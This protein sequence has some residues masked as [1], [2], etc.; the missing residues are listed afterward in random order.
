[1]IDVK[2]LPH[3]NNINTQLRLRLK[4]FWNEKCIFVS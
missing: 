4:A 2:H 1:M 3:S